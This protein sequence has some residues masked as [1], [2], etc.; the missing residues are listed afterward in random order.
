MRLVDLF[1]RYNV[2]G[3][4]YFT[5]AGVPAELVLVEN[6]GHSFKPE[7]GKTISPSRQEIAQRVAEFFEEQLK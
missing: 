5:A 7:E 1:E 6:A 3:D 2:R 4:F